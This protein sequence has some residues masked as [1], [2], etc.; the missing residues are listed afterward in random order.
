MATSFHQA[1]SCNLFTLTSDMFP[2]RAVASVVGIGGFGGS[3]AMVLFGTFVGCVLK[4]THNNYVPVFILAGSAY[5]VAI[6]VIHLL[7]PNLE[8]VRD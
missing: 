4:L 8:P 5:L 1:W 7:V 3:C 2:R 6:L